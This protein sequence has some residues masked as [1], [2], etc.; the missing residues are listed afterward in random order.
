MSTPVLLNS[1]TPLPKAFS[2]RLSVG[3]AYVLSALLLSAPVLAQGPFDIER[4]G[5]IGGRVLAA[6]AQGAFAY[7]GQG[8]TLV[9]LNVSG[10]AFEKVA[11]VDFN[12]LIAQV[13]VSGDRVYVIPGN[14][15]IILDIS[16]P[17]N[18]TILSDTLIGE[19]VEFSRQV[20]DFAMDMELAGDILYVVRRKSDPADPQGSLRLIDVSDPANPAEL[21]Q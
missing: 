1:F 14:R 17:T 15:L 3:M 19:A 21:A 2:F 7:V 16:D 18:P 20:L 8:A 4:G 11:E 5:R 9:V 13:L 6:D 12:A 10:P